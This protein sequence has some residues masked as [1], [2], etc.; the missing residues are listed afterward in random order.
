M[1]MPTP[2]TTEVRAAFASSHDFSF[3][4]DE[5]GMSSRSYSYADRA[6]AFDQWLESTIAFAK[7]SGFEEGKAAAVSDI[8]TGES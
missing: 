3:H 6:L 1:A 7:A 4:E 8:A 2:L 5:S